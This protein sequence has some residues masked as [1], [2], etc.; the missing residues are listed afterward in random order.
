MFQRNEF[1]MKESKEIVSGAI[2][3]GIAPVIQRRTL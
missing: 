3:L 1:S 2:H